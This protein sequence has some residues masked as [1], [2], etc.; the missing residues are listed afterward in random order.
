MKKF[1]KYLLTFF[2]SSPILY[3]IFQGQCFA[4]TVTKTI[5]PVV[6]FTE[7]IPASP[8]ILEKLMGLFTVGNLEHILAIVGA[9]A[10]LATLT[11]N[12]TDNK[13]CNMI[14]KIINSIGMNFGL[15]QNKDEKTN[16]VAK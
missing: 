12:K 1:K 13:V 8:S 5:T 15:A 3:V 2:F 4:R 9:F 11:A 6:E 10:A 14:L 16:E 7:N